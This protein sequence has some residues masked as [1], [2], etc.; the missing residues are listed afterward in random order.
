MIF[1]DTYQRYYAQEV[2]GGL[3]AAVEYFLSPEKPNPNKEVIKGMLKIMSKSDKTGMLYYPM[4]A[5]Y[6]SVLMDKKAP[7]LEYFNSPLALI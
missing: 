7:L 3:F 6:I 2:D 5:K 1:L 4:I